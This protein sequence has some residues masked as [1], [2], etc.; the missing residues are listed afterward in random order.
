MTDEEYDRALLGR[1]PFAAPPSR[2]G[3]RNVPTPRNEPLDNEYYRALVGQGLLM[4]WGDEAEAWLR[5]KLGNRAYEDE[6]RDIR[7]RYADFQERNPTGA[8]VAEFVGGALPAVGSLLAVPFTAG[9]AAPAAAAATARSAGALG[10]LAG[11]YAPSVGIGAGTGAVTGA[12]TADEGDRVNEAIVGGL[13][14]AGAGAAIPAAMQGVSGIRKMYRDRF[15]R[16][17]QDLSDIAA[18]RVGQVMERAGVTPA[19]AEA[20]IAADRAAGIPSTLANVDPKLAA[21]LERVAGRSEGTERE[22]VERLT[23]QLEGSRFRGTVQTQQRLQAGDLFQQEEDLARDLRRRASQN[24]R[25]AYAVGDVDD[26]VIRQLMN[27]KS[28]RE[29]YKDAQILAELD[30]E[31][32]ASNAITYGGRV[33][34]AATSPSGQATYGGLREAAQGVQEFNPADFA[35]RQIGET[36]DVRTIDYLKRA[37]DDRIRALRSSP[38]TTAKAQLD[39]L[40]T[41][42]NNLRDRTKEVVP[43]YRKAL[44]QYAGDLEVRDALRLG[45]EDFNKLPR[46]EIEKMFNRAPNAGGMSSAEKDA[47]I[48]GVNRYLYARM[49]EAPTGQNS[50]GRLIRSPEMGEKLRPLFGSD[51]RFNLF[52]AALERE[53]QLFEQGTNALKAAVQGGRMRAAGEITDDSAIGQML[54]DMMHQSA[55]GTLTSMAA[56]VAR[57][58]T[59][60]DEAAQRITNMLLSSK[61]EEVAAAVRA[62]ENYSERAARSELTG[63]RREIGAVMGSQ[64][65][66]TQRNAPQE[67]AEAVR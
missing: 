63:R 3:V 23:P 41:I 18:E 31:K 58:S 30:A 59:I 67:D 6:V 27:T 15:G 22:V 61:P 13:I 57:N 66:A 16:S 17:E 10:R 1:D 50:V 2:L 26:D 42:R 62:I 33:G 38:D 14:G 43:E 49:M 45:F 47:F 19:Q 34:N 52:K 65:S 36:P 60:S 12:G 37:M 25:A 64:T 55:R 48:T 20:R 24:Y 8:N 21:A 35:L 5:S 54:G 32:A 4:G 9:A 29:A 53:G 56:R 44:E 39:A 46:E 28:V 51:D 7:K 40:S 11:R